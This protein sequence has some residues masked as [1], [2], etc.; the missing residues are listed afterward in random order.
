MGNYGQG[1]GGLAPKQATA[2]KTQREKAKVNTLPGAID[3]TRF[4]NG[5]QFKGEVTD[6]FVEAVISAQR[7]VTDAIN[8]EAIR[9]S[10]I[11]RSRST[12]T[13][14]ERICPRPRSRPPKRNWTRNGRY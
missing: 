6:E 11:R 8:R 10:I 2:F 9:D 5:E 3:S 4:V 7:D 13:G 14:R 1:Q 12:S